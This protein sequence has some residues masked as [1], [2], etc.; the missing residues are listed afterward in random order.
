M[1]LRIEKAI[2]GGDGLARIPEGK[3][4]FVPGTLPGE[5]VEVTIAADRRS[6]ATS[7]L[8]AI[9]EASPERVVPGCEYVPRCGGCQYQHAN[10]A[11]QLQM[12]LD[13]L[14]ET[15]D[16]AHVPVPEKIACVSGPAWGY[17]NR[18]RLHGAP[19]GVGY[20]ERAS[21]RVLR[22]TGCPIASPL[23]E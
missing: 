4:V 11:F 10:P 17:R 13:I 9:V 1:K 23:L 7:E 5:L 6:F 12:K 18:I 20:R 3:T 15:F 19:G 8:A 16:R 14:R 22:V 21:H 2:Y